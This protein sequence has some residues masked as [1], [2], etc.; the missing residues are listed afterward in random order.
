MG[1]VKI[2]SKNQFSFT[3]KCFQNTYSPQTHAT[4]TRT[5]WIQ[6]IFNSIRFFSVKR[7]CALC[8]QTITWF[9]FVCCRISCR[10]NR[11]WSRIECAT[12]GNFHGVWWDCVAFVT[13]SNDNTTRW[14]KVS[15]IEWKRSR[16]V[17]IISTL[18]QLHSH[19]DCGVLVREWS[20]SYK[21]EIM[22]NGQRHSQISQIPMRE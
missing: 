12:I 8:R 17:W 5:E 11:M 3:R 18:H 2:V 10:L 15:S 22:I 16:F 1:E 4:F 19:V 7:M 20:K 9:P 14:Q 13:A 6:L 21:K